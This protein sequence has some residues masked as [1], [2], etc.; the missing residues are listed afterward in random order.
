LDNKE[1][2]WTIL[3]KS[4]QKEK[5]GLYKGS[6]LAITAFSSA[7]YSRI[8]CS[9]AHLP[10]ALNHLHFLIVPLASAIILITARPKDRN[11][12]STV[13]M[14]FGGLLVLFW[15][16]AIS[17][18]I[19]DAGLVN[20]I[21]DFLMLGGPFI[22][23][24]AIID[25]PMSQKSFEQF[26]GWMVKSSYAN[27]ALA[28]IQWPLL[29]FHKI[30][31]GGLDE[32][33][34]MSGVFFVSG[35]GN[36]VSTT[37][38]IYFAIYFL[39][40]ANSAP[41]W[42]RISTLFCAFLQLQLS[43]SKQVI[44]ALFVGAILLTLLT[45]KNIGKTIAYTIA[46]ILTLIIF[47]WC[48]QNVEAFAAFKNYADKGDAYGPNGE[49]TRIKPIAFHI[50]PTFYN[51][52]LNWLVGLGPGHTVGRLGGWLL[53]ENWAILGPLGATRHPVSDVMLD[54]YYH[55]WLAMESTMFCPMFGWAGIWGDLG[56][57][58]LGAYL[59]LGFVVWRYVCVDNY[60]KFLMLSTAAFGLIFTQMEEPGYMLFTAAM[61]G[62]RWQEKQAEQKNVLLQR[63]EL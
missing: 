33:D 10:S 17:T 50:I 4:D 16:M 13:W 42:L 54:K 5:K 60:C 31:A 56:F 47:Y 58:G 44:F 41:F 6:T 32:T 34:G 19:N 1:R 20:L 27:M 9:V 14:L 11:Q 43:D 62:L 59:F 22:L 2:I 28:F 38:S 46:I 26:Q 8:V 49:A 29:K 7:F 40:Y 21:F 36:Y 12:V 25:L 52:A 45:M 63:Y 61:I 57:V 39:I 55:S 15:A 53:K 35:A 51:S 30:S 3:I 23:L 24:I 37:V 18:M 48:I